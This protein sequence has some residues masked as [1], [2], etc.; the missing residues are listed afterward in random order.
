MVL[1][2]E[3]AGRGETRELRVFDHGF[4]VE[5]DGETFAAE[6][7]FK[8]VP[9]AD[10]FIGAD[11]RGDAGAD[12][13]RH[14]GVHAVAVH[15]A[16]ADGPAP[17]VELGLAGAAQVNAG[18][19]VGRGRDE[20]FAV[21]AFFVGAVGEDGGD[22]VEARG[23]FDA[24][25]EAEGEVAVGF[26]GP[27]IF[28][29]GSFGAGV[30]VDDAVEDFPVAVVADGRFPPGEVAA[31]EERDPARGKCGRGRGG[32]AGERREG[33]RGGE[34]GEETGEFHGDVE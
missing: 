14:F 17:D 18:V 3:R 15:F 4:S 16:G 34:Q 20:V 33:E 10:G 7:D 19:G 27:E 32:R 8:G 2:G 5:D 22:G 1:E 24:P 25:V 12:G 26:F 28:V 6:G 30:V 23:L 29:A 13:G 9:F 21:G 31:V 11:F